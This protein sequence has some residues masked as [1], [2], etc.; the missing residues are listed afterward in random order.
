MAAPP[1]STALEQITADFTKLYP[2]IIVTLTNTP[3]QSQIAT[4]IG[5]GSSP[6]VVHFV[7]SDAVPEYA[8]RGALQ[9]L[10]DLLAKDVPDWKDRVYWY[11]PEA[12]SYNGKVF[13][14]STA[15]FNIGLLWNRDIFTEVGLD[16][17]KGPQTM[18]ELVEWAA[19]MDVVD[20]DGNIQRLGFVPDYPGLAN[21]QVCNLILYAWA[22]GG[23][24]YDSATNKITANHPKNI[25]ALKW[26]LAF[27]EKYGGQKVKNFLASAGGYLTDQDVFRTGKVG[28]VYDGEW[29]IVFPTADFPFNVKNINAGGFPA[30]K[31]NPD[32]FGVSY[33]DSNPICLPAGSPHPTEAWEFMKFMCFNPQQCSNF[34]QVVANPCQ[35]LKSPPYALQN[36]QRFEWFIKQ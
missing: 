13:A 2:N 15:N 9:D 14:V 26:E 19:K 3:D 17:E 27:Y 11:T 18:E 24:W 28:M 25:E 30:P 5:S 34:A 20:K 16:P 31:D 35:L 1:N 33:A 6:D 21:G 22:M 29:N 10:T 23:D 32:M 12:N 8:H 36:D 7:L 4:A